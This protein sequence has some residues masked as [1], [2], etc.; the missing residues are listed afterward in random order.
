MIIAQSSKKSR[1]KSTFFP[2]F[3]SKLKRLFLPGVD[4]QF[5]YHG[6]SFLGQSTSA[7]SP[8]LS[9]STTNTSLP[10]VLPTS[11]SFT[12][13]G[14]SPPPS[15]NNSNVDETQVHTQLKPLH[16]NNNIPT[17]HPNTSASAGGVLTNT[18][19]PPSSAE[20]ISPSSVSSGML[21]FSKKLS[22]AHCS[23]SAFV[24]QKFNFEFPRKIA[25]KNLGE[26]LVKMLRF[27]T[28]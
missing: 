16:I 4:F 10:S 27:C 8:W 5:Q 23:K 6:E 25:Q 2:S 1:P 14:L 17:I 20:A 3:L 9:S 26:K 24:V 18:P 7:G 28:F 13:T 21:N 15:S 19:T 11:S 12:D 22:W